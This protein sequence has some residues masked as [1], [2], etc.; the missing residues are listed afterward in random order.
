MHRRYSVSLELPWWLGGEG[1]KTTENKIHWPHWLIPQSNELTRGPLEIVHH[2]RYKGGVH[3]GARALHAKIWYGLAISLA[4]PSWEEGVISSFK[5]FYLPSLR[6]GRGG[7]RH[8][9]AHPYTTSTPFPASCLSFSVF[10]CVVGRAY[11]Q[12]RGQG[13][14]WGRSQILRRR[15]SWKIIQYSLSQTIH[16]YSSGRGESYFTY[17]QSIFRR[18]YTVLILCI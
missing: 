5:W 8:P 9:V 6:V 15:G 4:Y 12:E 10:L 7:G 2:F 1:V 18:G 14:R 13:R 17:I 3:I 11:W 16:T